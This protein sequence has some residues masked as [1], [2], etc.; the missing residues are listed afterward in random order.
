MAPEK[1]NEVTSGY[2][3]LQEFVRRFTKA[4]GKIH[5]G[6]DPNHVVPGYAVHAEL[7]MLVEAG[8]TPLQAIQTASTNVAQ[9][10]GKEK[11]FGS[12]EKGKVADLIIV[13]GDPLRNISDTQ[14]I[15]SVFI[16]G[17]KVDTSYH[18]DYKNPIPRP[19]EDRPE[20]GG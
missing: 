20:A 11:D 10:W 1:R 13:R 7:Q 14:N 16:D 8:L 15:E 18:A 6:S 17:K 12:V 2:K 9:A 4:G 19:I 3:M 5:S